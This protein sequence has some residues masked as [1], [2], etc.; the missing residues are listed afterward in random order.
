MRREIFEQGAHGQTMLTRYGEEVLVN[1]VNCCVVL[2][3]LTVIYF[4]TR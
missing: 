3:V 2:M 4:F 1:F